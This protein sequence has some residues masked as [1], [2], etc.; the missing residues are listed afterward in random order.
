MNFFLIVMAAMAM[1]N[2]VFISCYISTISLCA[3]ELFGV[4]KVN[5]ASRMFLFFN[6]MGVLI[7]PGSSQ[8][9]CQ[10]IVFQSFLV[11]EETL[12]QMSLCPF[13]SAC[14]G[15]LFEYFQGDYFYTMST[16]SAAYTISS[17]LSLL[18]WGFNR[19]D[20]IL[21]KTIESQK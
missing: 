20:K 17:T 7:F 6:G 10:R 19:R 14:L 9:S 5:F 11:I 12:L 15:V 1:T 16:L 8:F 13:I 2:G 3:L 21:I 18:S 4:D